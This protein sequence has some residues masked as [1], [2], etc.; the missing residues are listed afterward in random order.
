MF[1][2]SLEQ[3]AQLPLRNRATAIHFFVLYRGGGAT[4]L[5]DHNYRG[6]GGYRPPG[7]LKSQLCE[8]DAEM[9]S[10]FLTPIFLA[11]LIVTTVNLTKLELSGFF[12]GLKT[13]KSILFF[14]YFP[15][16]E[17]KWLS[18]KLLPNM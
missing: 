10:K 2:F 7:G 9:Q 12:W 1:C 14:S 16:S 3:E 18:V 15:P 11:Y 17:R 4:A 5:L 6:E 8:I 13:Q